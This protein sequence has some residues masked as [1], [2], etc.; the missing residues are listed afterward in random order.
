MLLNSLTYL[1]PDTNIG[2]FI[3]IVQGIFSISGGGVTQLN[4][5]RY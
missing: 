1:I 4:I 5:S 3:S 2:H